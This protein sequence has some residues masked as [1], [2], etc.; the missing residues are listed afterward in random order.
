MNLLVVLKLVAVPAT[1]SPAE[2]V[3]RI[4]VVFPITLYVFVVPKLPD[5]AWMNAPPALL[6]SF[7]EVKGK[8]PNLIW[9]EV[10]VAPVILIVNV[11]WT[12]LPIFV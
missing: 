4:S 3:I 10:R 7:T 11:K 1:A 8:P 9:E 6:A 2:L 5:D 12:V